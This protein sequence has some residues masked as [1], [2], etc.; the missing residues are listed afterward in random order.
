MEI[1]RLSSTHKNLVRRYLLW[2]Y[3]STK[4]DFERIERKTTQLAVDQYVFGHFSKKKYHVPDAFKQYIGDKIKDE[5]KL[6]F[7][8]TTKKKFNPQ[9]LYLK[10]RLEAIEEAIKFFL[11]KKELKNFEVLFE[12]EFTQRILGS[13]EH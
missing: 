13:R 2:A 4:E 7:A 10:H 12:K 5:I 6:K 3:K 8:D 11:G 9:Y 1:K